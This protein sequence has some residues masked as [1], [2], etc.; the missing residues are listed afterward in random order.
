LLP[1]KLEQNVRARLCEESCLQ[2]YKIT[3]LMEDME[4]RILLYLPL[5]QQDQITV[6]KLT[7]IIKHISQDLILP[8][9]GTHLCY[10]SLQA[11]ERLFLL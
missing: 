1:D 4:S 6:N 8:T 7:Q 3:Y 2:E 10:L 5:C 11:E 9:T